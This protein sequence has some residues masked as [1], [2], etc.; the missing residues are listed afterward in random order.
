MC[1]TPDTFYI[2]Q[3][4]GRTDQRLQ[5]KEGRNGGMKVVRVKERMQEKKKEETTDDRKKGLL[6]ERKGTDR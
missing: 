3:Q 1:E 5:G 4:K 2:T 6:K